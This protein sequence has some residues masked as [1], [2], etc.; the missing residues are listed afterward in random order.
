[1]TDVRGAL[2]R[3]AHALVAAVT[4]PELA[5]GA[6]DE[7]RE[8]LALDVVALYVPPGDGRPVLVRVAMATSSPQVSLAR[9][10]LVFDEAAWRL[11]V[12]GDAPLVMHERA[13]WLVE[14]PFAPPADAWLLLPLGTRAQRLGVVIGGA[15]A[16]PAID[17]G[18]AAV[19]RML[20]DLLGAGIES[21]RLRRELERTAVER[22]RLRL[23]AEVHDGLAQDLALAVRELALL[24]SGPAEAIAEASQA[25][26]RAAV[27]SAHETV[28][29]R[30]AGIFA[31]SALTG[32]QPALQELQSRFEERGLRAVLSGD[33]ELPDVPPEITAVALRVLTEALS[34]VEHHAPGASVRIEA[35]VAGARLSLVVADDGP[36]FVAGPPVAG[37]FG[38][39]LM[40]ERTRTA[41]GVLTVDS[42]PGRGSRI[43]LDLPLSQA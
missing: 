20:G 2:R 26:L 27:V 33:D 28:R 36:G 39:L 30:L 22:E 1:V 24:D 18:A 25:R 38:L 42:A 7:I 13:E 9:E 17:A 34:N 29:A 41:G 35:R 6:L 23:A 32:L 21:A 4:L 40:R 19:L 15:R 14:H 37:H 10:R 5:Q 31:A 16:L 11:A 8:T 43:V 12:Q 3:T